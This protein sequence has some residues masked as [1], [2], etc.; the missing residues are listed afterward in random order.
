[1]VLEY[2]KYYECKKEGEIRL[3]RLRKVAKTFID[4]ADKSKMSELTDGLLN[5]LAS[6]QVVYNQTKMLHWI[7]SGENYIEVHQFFDRIA[8]TILNKIDLLAERIV[9]LGS[10]PINESNQITQRSYVIYGRLDGSFDQST[11][12]TTMN[13]SLD[14]VINGL[15]TN[16]IKAEEITDIGTS[17][18]V[19]E[20]I[21]ELESLQHHVDSFRNRF[22]STLQHDIYPSKVD[23]P[24][25]NDINIEE[26]LPAEESED[27][28]VDLEKDEDLEEES[29]ED[30]TLDEE[31]E[32]KP[33]IPN[34]PERNN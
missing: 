8:H 5:D 16:Y 6:L 9:Y 19:Q 26:S 25:V 10:T 23:L 32:N 20:I 33:K 4:Q 15:R 34:I 2:Y 21:F 14:R 30:I 1:M 29:T 12:M 18:L 17:Q 13:D 7:S 3:T 24:L 31:K 28:T 22:T 27:L 11:A